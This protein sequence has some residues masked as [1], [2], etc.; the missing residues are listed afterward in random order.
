MAASTKQTTTTATTTTTTTKMLCLIG[1]RRLVWLLWW[2]MLMCIASSVSQTMAEHVC[3]LEVSEGVPIGYQIGYIGEFLHGV[4]SGPPYLIVPVQGSAVEP[5]LSIDHTT[6]EIRTKVLLDRETRASYSFVAIPISGDN[7]KVLIRVLDENDNA[8]IFP[9]PSMNIEFPENTPRDVK[10]T[11]NPARDL[12]LGRYNTQ[13]YNIVSGNV[14]NA[15]RLSSHR[16]RDG[17]LY[18]DLQI[19]GFLDRETTPFYSLVIEAI[20]GGNPPLRGQMS[21]NIS[22][23]DVNDNT[24]IFNQSRYFAS[25]PE[26]A[27]IGTKVLQ[28]YASDIDAGHN[29]LIEFSINR[30]QSD[31]E[32]MFQIDGKTGIISVNKPL[33][34][35]TKELHELVVVARD[36]GEQP[37]ETT[38]FVSISVTNVNDNQP[39]INVIF[40][41]DDATPK[42]S[43]DAQPGEFVAR[44]SVNDPDSK[45]EYSNVNVSLIGGDGHFGL[46][47]RDSIIYLVIISLPL[48]REVQPNYTLSIVATDQG[49]PPLHASKTIYLKVTDCNDNAPEFE[50]EIYHA[51]VMEVADPGTSVLQVAAID[52]DEGNNS[53]ITYSILDTPNTHSDWFQID[54]NTGLITTRTHIDC[55]T[56]PVPQLIVQARDNG[57]PPMSSTATVFIQ[58]HDV[59]D[60]EPIFDQSFYNATV[61]ENDPKGKCILKVSAS[62]PDCGVNAMVNYTIGDGFKKMMEFEV[63]HTTGDI[64]ISGMLDF[65]MR[66]SYE[67]PI[68]ATDQ[69]G[70]STTA[71]VKIQVTD[72][73]DNAPIF[74]PTE[75]NVSLRE[76]STGS[77]AI[78]Q[79]VASDLDS[80]HF[81]AVTYRIVS[82]NEASIFR[83]DRVTGEIFV[84]KPS[85]LSSRTQP[86]H[87][88]NISAS[89]GGGL[90]SSQNAVV[91][92][93]VID[94]M[95]R[96]PIFEKTRYTYSVKEDVA[97]GTVVG[98]I[99]ATSSDSGSR[100]ITKYSIYGGDPD[101][102]F[103]I[104]SLSGNIRIAN[105]LD[106]ET[107]SQV[108][109]N[110]QAISGDRPDYAH[111]QVTIY[112]ED[113]N[114][115]APEFESSTVRISIPENVELGTPLYAANAHDKDSGK[116]GTVRY[117]L[118]NVDDM[119]TTNTISL[120]SSLSTGDR[121]SNPNLFS[122]DAETGHLTLLHHLDY[123]TAQRH[124]LIVTASDLGEPSLTANLTILVEV[125]DVNDNSPAFERNEYSISVIESTQINAQVLQVTATD[126]DTGN[127]AR[128]TYRIVSGSQMFQP[129]HDVKQRSKSSNTSKGNMQ[130]A[131]NITDIFGMFPNNGWLY[132]R[133]ELDREKCDY[134]D[135]TV[136]VNDNG[137]PSASATTHVIVN[138][139]D[140]NDNDPVFMQDSYE[141]TV[142]ENARRNTVVGVVSASDIDL[143]INAELKYNLIPD[144]SSFHVNP[145]TGEIITR[146]TLDR[147]QHA[148]Y[149]FVVEARDQGTPSR[150]SRAQVRIHINDI[151]DNAPEIVD[152]QEDVVSVREEQPPGTYVVRIRA[153]DRDNGYNAS[154]TYSILKGRDS[155]GYGLF[156]IDSSTG[157]I[158]TRV[159]LDHEERSIYRLAI[160]AN[161]GGKPS[162]QT[163]R[164]LRVEVLNLNDNRPTFTSSS[165]IYKV[166]E[167]A[168]IG[169]IVGFIGSTDRSDSDNMIAANRVLQVTYTLNSIST[170]VIENAFDIDRSTGSLV[171]ARQLDREQQ[172][173]YRLEVRALD[174]TATNNPQSSAVNI[175]IEIID[176]N[177]NY[178]QWPQDPI[179]IKMVEN[180]PI[181]M[182]LYNFTA[183]D[184]DLGP[185]GNIQYELVQQM[186]W[187]RK[188]FSVDPLT[189]TL[190]QLLPIDYEDLNEYLLVVKATDQSTNLSERLSSL[191]TARISVVDANDNGPVFV[192]PNADNAMIY[193]SESLSI[194]DVVTRVIAIDK[195]S[196]NNSRISYSIISGNEEGQ[197]EMN[198]MTGTIKLL[199]PFLANASNEVIST[200]SG[201]S[202]KHN[203]VISAADN[204]SPIPLSTQINAQI[205]VQ[206]LTTNP[207][208]FSEPIYY[209]NISEN[210]PFGTFVA[211][212]SAKSY[213]T[214]SGRSL[215]FEIPAGVGDDVFTVDSSRGIVTTRGSIDRESKDVYMIPIYV[216]EAAATE[217]GNS[218]SYSKTNRNAMTLFDVATLVIKINDVNDH[219]PEFRTGTCYPLAVP[220]NH[221]AT[222][223]HTVVA[224]DLD[225]GLNGDII[226]TITGGN[227]GNR[228]SI[229][230]HTG[231]LTA[232]P[233][234]REQKAR[235]LLQITAQDRGSPITYQG[236]CNISIAV[237]DQNDSNPH[238]ELSKYTV[239]VAEDVA[240]G[241]PI[242]TVKATDADI[243][244]NAQI[245]YSLANETDWLF[246]VD[247][248]SGVITTTGALDR[249]KTRVFNFMVVA[250]DG[251]LYDAREQSVP[252]QIVIEDVN[253]NAPI[254]EKYPF[255][256]Q[257]STFVQPGQ[258]LI[259]VS[260]TDIDEGANG[261]VVYS[262]AS[263]SM[264]DKFRLNPSTGIL[265]ATKSLS[266][267][268]GRL[269]HLKIVARD[270]GNPP[271]ST[272]GFIELRVGDVASDYPSLHFQNELYPVSL[273]EN[274][275]HGHTVVQLNA[276]RSDGRRQKIIYS[277]ESGNDNGAF[278]IDAKTGEIKVENSASLD[279]EDRNKR[280]IHLVVVA[281][282][283]TAPILYGYCTV[284]VHLQDENDNAP[285]FTQRQYEASVWEGNNKGTFVM[286]VKAFDIDEG[287]N[288]RV[289]YHIVDGNHDNA[290]V[291]EPA[292][293]GTVKTN[294]VLDR[295]IR[296]MYRLKVIATD[297][298]VPQMTGTATIHVH[299]IDVND[300]QPTFPPH[301]VINI[302]EGT[303]LGT[304]LT[305][306]SAN[307]VDTYPSL[308]YSFD[309]VHTDED[310]LAL[311]AIDRFSGK[312]LLKRPLDYEMRQEYQL[313]ILASD[314]K[315]TAQS[316]L[317]IHIADENDNAPEFTQLMYQTTISAK[318][319][320]GIIEVMK[321]NA[322]DLDSEKNAGQR[323][324][325]VKPVP[326]F[327][328]GE[329][330][331]IISANAS[332]VNKLSTNDVQFSVMATDSG[333]PML[334]STAAVR[335]KVIPNNL[336]K[337]HFIQ[338]Q[339]RSTIMESAELGTVLLKLTGADQIELDSNQNTVYQIISGND[340]DTFDII[341]P[342]NALVLVKQLDRETTQSYNL[343]LAL[344]D[345]E[346]PNQ[347]D[348]NTTII[349]VFVSIED[350]NDNAPVFQTENYEVVVSEAVPLKYSIAKII[351]TDGDLENTPNSEIVYDITSGNDDG[352]FS[353]DLISGVLLV[354]KKLDY[355][356]GHT[357]YSVVIRACDSGVVAL[358]NICQFNI[359]LTDENDNEPHF[360]V[361]E[362]VEF[363]A[364]NEPIAVSV[365]TARAVDLDKGKYGKLNYSIESASAIGQSDVDEAWKL[366]KIDP[367]TGIVITNAVFDYEQKNRYTFAIKAT[368]VGGKSAYVKVHIM[369][370]SRDEYSPQFTERTYRFGLATPELD[371]LPVGYI[372]FC[373]V[374]A[375]DRDK[376]PDGRVVYQLTTQHPYFKINR[377]TGAI[378]IKRKLN[379]AAATLEAGRDMSL[380]VTAS[381]GRQGS[382]T[383]MTV[384]EIALDA[385]SNLSTNQASTI[386]SGGA[387]DS[388]IADWAL[389]LLIS[390][391]LVCISFG[392]VFLF[393][394]F[395]NRRHKQ[396][397]K[398]NLS[399]ETVGNT[400]SYVDPSAFDTI[401]IRANASVNNSGP[402]A[403]PKYDEIPP[404][405]H[406]SRS[407]NATTSELSGSQQSGSSGRGSAEDDGEDEE[408]RMINE[409]PLQRDNGM[410][411]ENGRQSDVSV[412]NTQEY[413]ARLGIVDNNLTAGA[414]TS[415]RV[416]STKDAILHHTLPI[417]SLHMF[418]EDS[419]HNDITNLIYAKLND[420]TV[421]SD[422]A[423][424]VDE[425][426]T[427][428]G[429]I[430][431]AVDH[432]MSGYP[433]VAGNPGPSMNGSLSSI[434]HSEEELTGSYN[435]DY[436]LDWGPQYQPLAHVFSEIARLKDDT[437]SLHSGNSGASG[438]SKATQHPKHIPPPLLTHIAPRSVLTTRG[439]SSHTGSVNQYLLPRSPISH[440]SIAGFSTSSA[441]SPSFS[442]S[443]SPLATQSPSIS[444]H[445]SNLPTSHRK[446]C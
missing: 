224:T 210:I 25:V 179:E 293:S 222:I 364:E 86:H 396:V 361:S 155:D 74:Y 378:M 349:N 325:L 339:Y 344:N 189:G 225:D 438:K 228:F 56:E 200:G 158:R 376:G 186:P 234:D 424:C 31:R 383:N 408:I 371:T 137:T 226:Y 444:P 85:L 242:L 368:D 197:F 235:Y 301:N 163:V 247:N 69:G 164:L 101:G 203:L 207:P 213:H 68:I 362:Y 175:K 280:G 117:R 237:E 218:F 367:I 59:N 363:V 313:K 443:L 428:A 195:D 145:N 415:S 379:N 241:T 90:R 244:S 215:L 337:P 317:T 76:A 47:T 206:G 14:N 71:I 345:A 380:V 267:D 167:D 403:P 75:Y 122:I 375:T 114:D 217:F 357:N 390:L 426:A 298:G 124:A 243:G 436:L 214:D 180:S 115:N 285:R 9:S 35:E 37:L 340:N 397:I 45:T 394:H 93:N 159:A 306:A 377:T 359:T 105:K 88:L 386:N 216:T 373:C 265:T 51:N 416:G 321:V 107:K 48:D 66:S 144:N 294:I 437:L 21:V 360:A 268:N 351:A 4:D 374:L 149:D 332:Q 73:N 296:D 132:L 15:F 407:N 64:C 316:T 288:S 160:A 430:D 239:T 282:T 192:Y 393:L 404:C 435:W 191:V 303:E 382:L 185:N 157:I 99:L 297:E 305:I 212:V 400:N 133:S 221:E 232:G 399:S 97:R 22:I 116:S 248:R 2:S 304:V 272:F 136:V 236:T 16:E 295:E 329:T 278:E 83:I 274:V 314:T 181:G 414:S 178:P 323:Y 442:P 199:K 330:T 198:S 5:D 110:I 183:T 310:A 279:Y 255:K 372:V 446:I 286:Q 261:E 350:A 7:I 196:N 401:P 358:C 230:M 43:E 123:E 433:V 128:L 63:K 146:E 27:T 187:N 29:G 223:I 120:S 289:L 96:P 3:E 246:S 370:D 395:K 44:I 327:Y 103:S 6:G 95:H 13:R 250:T 23:Q 333:I 162:K 138:V 87:K 41:S 54:Q 391:I 147:E 412:Q 245:V 418:D 177:D 184:L 240:I 77:S 112:I 254:F 84:S 10:R 347:M 46:T 165:L 211:R 154:I 8:P 113:V 102:Y 427:T 429:S 417:D 119:H 202:R 419:H 166:R 257:I 72:F 266:E 281:H 387:N 173:E 319:S 264:N 328:I 26:N 385:L 42:I 135:L 353:I 342:N 39:I 384:V 129:R 49:N 141:F 18:L 151:N 70:L 91:Y 381:S 24:P 262:L 204:G 12:D 445:V 152:P 300:N 156:S 431:A 283:D 89:D 318:S 33:D 92:I 315:Y 352:L 55:E 11:L 208:K 80:D 190:T 148:S 52:R 79:V 219:A 356:Q 290:F 336:V 53:V 398:P 176:Q 291:I 28:V 388:G 17:V 172:S 38:A 205:F 170:D 109:L 30:R 233:L 188:T 193:V 292:F 406:S 81:G 153:I 263:D 249:E 20:D 94:S 142:D 355:D 410:H 168:P 440:D 259:Q 19:N 312:V 111:T 269:I 50:K 369:I 309:E 161:D 118:T 174:T 389:G 108:L 253:D 348:D 227:F 251:G 60:N 104:D 220:E 131:A 169:Y 409:G 182:A 331:G 62:D 36:H 260:A 322:T 324:S 194:G 276:V 420:V 413:L 346:I 392:A 354:N 34:F 171:V 98:S 307:D 434:V 425:A 311:F 61:S 67:F 143:G 139:L 58:I 1:M 343:R 341:Q 273:M 302:G 423:S 299:I 256:N 100:S 320:S 277:I 402:F 209:A 229:D 287:A 432:M 127:N 275:P 32:Q 150:S 258:K 78:V 65:E 439:N 411:M 82:G 334:K 422:R 326:G 366:F 134:Y 284:V 238:F 405:S 201:I 252:V 441:M 421:G 335:I 231:E 130:A 338:N 125:Q 140:A 271:Q 106:H 57:V 365:F 121:K 126:L 308:A 40:L 270:K